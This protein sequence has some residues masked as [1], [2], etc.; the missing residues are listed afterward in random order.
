[1]ADPCS[2]GA[3]MFLKPSLS[4]ISNI[5]TLPFSRAVWVTYL[6]T[7]AVLCC[8]LHVVQRR[9]GAI[10]NSAETQQLSVSDSVM[11]AIGIVCQEGLSYIFTAFWGDGVGVDVMTSLNDAALRLKALRP[12]VGFVETRCAGNYGGPVLFIA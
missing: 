7:T 8:A 9:E 10:S 1:M 11:T 2:R 5:Y 6:V 4:D 3:F 12:Q